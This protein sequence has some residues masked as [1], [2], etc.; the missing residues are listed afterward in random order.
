VSSMIE[1]ITGFLPVHD[2]WYRRKYVFVVQEMQWYSSSIICCSCNSFI[3][4]QIYNPS[5]EFS[6][7]N[8]LR[9]QFNFC[10]INLLLIY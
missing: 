2:V 9:N 1:C 8:S 4:R 5:K 10:P 3:S 7:Q 6:E